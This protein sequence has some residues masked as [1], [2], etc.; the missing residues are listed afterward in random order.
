MEIITILVLAIGL[1]FDS[2]AVSVSTG[3]V[4]N[5]IQFKPALRFSFV[6]GIF[7][8]LFPLIGWVAGTSFQDYLQDYDHW[9]AF[10]L[11]GGLG[12]KMI[13]ES[14]QG[15][16]VNSSNYNPLKLSTNVSI[17]IATSIDAL[18]VGLSL[19]I[20]NINI[21][22]SASII[23][24][25]TVLACMIGLLLGKKIGNKLGRRVEILGGIMLIAIGLNIVLQHTHYL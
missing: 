8:G 3:I 9:I 12:V 17:G 20:L 10:L 22:L 2:F 15:T 1:S 24:A 18:I 11:L 5:Y 14:L 4:V 21:V 7:Q 13:Y 6:L 16:K 23:G 25:V 19:A